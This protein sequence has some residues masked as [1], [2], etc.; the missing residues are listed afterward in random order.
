MC[1]LLLHVYT[2]QIQ[3][4]ALLPMIMLTSML[5]YLK[6]YKKLYINVLESVVILDMVVLLMIASVSDVSYY[7]DYCV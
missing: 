2:F 7:Y 4:V 5:I 3:T 1:S 6:P